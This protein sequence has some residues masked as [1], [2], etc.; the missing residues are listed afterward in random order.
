MV[1]LARMEHLQLQLQNIKIQPRREKN[2]FVI[3]D[4]FWCH[5]QLRNLPLTM[6]DNDC[7]ATGGK[8]GVP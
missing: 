4:F 1:I 5:T 3:S 2:D 6:D 8:N 7:G